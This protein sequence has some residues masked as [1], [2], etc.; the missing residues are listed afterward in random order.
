MCRIVLPKRK[1]LSCFF[2]AVPLQE[3]QNLCCR[4][5]KIKERKQ[6][7]SPP[8]HSSYFASV[9]SP[10]LPLSK[11]RQSP[12]I[13]ICNRTFF[14]TSEVS[15][16]RKK[17]HFNVETC[18]KTVGDF[19]SIHAGKAPKSEGRGR[20]GF[21]IHISRFPPPPTPPFYNQASDTTNILFMVVVLV[22]CCFFHFCCCNILVGGKKKS[23]K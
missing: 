7:L 6:V 23:P 5:N 9:V 15:L 18:K 16:K 21:C 4:H 17:A 11:F 1:K 22:C 20:E 3:S 12:N 8:V 19:F 14:Q 13:C 2:C 10:P